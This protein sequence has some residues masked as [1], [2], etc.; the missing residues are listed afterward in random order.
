M[1]ASSLASR[2]VFRIAR[3]DAAGERGATHCVPL[4]SPCAGDVELH[5]HTDL[6]VRLD[7]AQYAAAALRSNYDIVVTVSG[8]R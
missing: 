1:P 7:Q 6:I 2:D 8:P 3:I 5:R 4:I